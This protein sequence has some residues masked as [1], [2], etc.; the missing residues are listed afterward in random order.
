MLAV[1]EVAVQTC[2]KKTKFRLMG[3]VCAAALFLPTKVADKDIVYI[4]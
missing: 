1:I 4:L 2:C 3:V